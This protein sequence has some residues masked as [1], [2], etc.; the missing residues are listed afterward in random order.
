MKMIIDGIDFH[1]IEA[2]RYWSFPK[3]Y[4]GNPKEETRNMIFSGDYIGSRKI[5]GVFYKFTKNMDGEMEL[6]GRSRSVSGDFLDKINWVPQ[7]MP[8]FNTL[9]NGT[10]LLGELYFPNNEGSNKVTTIMGCLVDKAITRQEKSK[11]HYYIFDCLAW[12]G[13]NYLDMS[14]D[15]RF[16][17]VSRIESAVMSEGIENCGYTEF[18]HYYTGIELWTELQTVLSSGGEGVV[19]TRRGTPYQ[20]GKRTARQ[21]LKIKKE[22]S[23]TIDAFFTGRITPATE[24]YKGKEIETWQYWKDMRTG[25]PFTDDDH[26]TYKRYVSGEMIK[27]ITRGAFYGWAGSLEVGVYGKKG[28]IIPIAWLSGLPDEIKAAPQ[29]YKMKPFEMTAMQI[30][31]D[32]EGHGLRHAKFLKWRP[33]ISLKE[34]TYEKIFGEQ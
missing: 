17:R 15:K 1:E 18:A 6:L 9:P 28:E 34:C 19:I 2:Q 10:C 23:D 11:L 30:H 21:S 8:F 7:L 25:L 31:D 4:K 16:D 3:S 27:P 14:C 26:N 13:K 29:E 33:D 20:P 22:L 32:T 5:D 24:D 12:N